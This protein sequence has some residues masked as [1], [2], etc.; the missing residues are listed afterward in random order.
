MFYVRLSR[1]DETATWVLF[2]NL[3][4]F[5]WKVDP[6]VDIHGGNFLLFSLHSLTFFTGVTRFLERSLLDSWRNFALYYTL[7]CV[8]YTSSNQEIVFVNFPL[9]TQKW[10]KGKQKEKVNN[11]VLFDQATY[12]KLLSE[13][14]KYKLITPSILSDRLRVSVL[15]WCIF[16]SFRLEFSSWL[17]DSELC[18]ML[19]GLSPQFYQWL[20]CRLMDPLRGGLSGNWC[21]KEPLDW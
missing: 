2:H 1:T 10:S 4:H 17:I 12:D 11:M 14:P 19:N 3:G 15:L 20:C 9:S 18:S 5:E 7:S 21:P 16:C 8:P 6:L 13:V